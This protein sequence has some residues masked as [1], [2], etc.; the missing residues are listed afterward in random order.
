[1]TVLVVEDDGII[2]EGLRFALEQ[3]GYQVLAASTMAQAMEMIE[4]GQQVDIYL[5]Y[6][7]KLDVPMP[8]LTP[9]ER[10]EQERL[11][12]KRAESRNYRHRKKLKEHAE[13]EAKEKAESQA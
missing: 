1:M 3:E 9:E 6:I 12:K 5:K 7:G 11:R 13:K 2:L 10:R 8:E 4:S